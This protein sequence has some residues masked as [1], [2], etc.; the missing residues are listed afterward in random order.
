M[1]SW[2]FRRIE[3]LSAAVSKNLAAETG[4]NDT[5]LRCERAVQGLRIR[6][7]EKNVA[8]IC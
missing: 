3:T 7:T 2:V 4:A 8:D 6:E 1:M 5:M